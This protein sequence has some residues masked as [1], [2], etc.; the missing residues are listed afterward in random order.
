MLVLNTVIFS[1][2]FLL[3][4]EFRVDFSAGN[5]GS[6]TRCAS[7]EDICCLYCLFVVCIFGC[8]LVPFGE[9]ILR[10]WV[11]VRLG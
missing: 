5:F 2:S 8:R 3:I 4:S 1:G 11:N 10:S 9:K 7:K 6:H